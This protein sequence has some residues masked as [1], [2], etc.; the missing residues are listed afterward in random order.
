MPATGGTPVRLTHNAVPD[1][2][3]Q[4]SPDGSRLVWTR[5][6]ATGASSLIVAAANDSGETTVTA[7]SDLARLPVWLRDGLR[8]A[9]IGLGGGRPALTVLVLNGPALR[10][11][12]VTP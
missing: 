7:A 8:I 11:F 4:W 5:T 1:V 12:P 9:Y 2:Q 3:P 6:S 10:L